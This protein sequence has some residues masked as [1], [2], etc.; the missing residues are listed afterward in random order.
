MKR[1]IL[2]AEDDETIAELIRYNLEKSG[3]R[4]SCRSSGEKALLAAGAET[5]DLV[6]LDILLPGID[7]IQV[8]RLLRGEQKTREVPIIMVTAK[9]E[10]N[11]I[12]EGLDVGADD[13]ITKPFSPKVLLARVQA[14]MRRR[15][16]ER[17]AENLAQMPLCV[18]DL[19]IDPQRHKVLIG[20]VRLELTVSEFQV[21]YFLASQPGRVFTRYQIVEAVRGSNYHVT[22]RAVDVLVF[23]LRRKLGDYGVYLETVRGVGYRFA[24][25]SGQPGRSAE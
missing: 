23:G 22:D 16:R 21:L 13:Y 25:V 12:V 11:D 5:P 19:V 17:S 18:H 2:V 24:E 1:H 7:G 10:E 8:C 9:G 14:V 6:I 3:F 15:A 4:V 20:E